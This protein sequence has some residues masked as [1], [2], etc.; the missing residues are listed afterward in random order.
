MIKMNLKIINASIIN[1]TTRLIFLRTY[2]IGSTEMYVNLIHVLGIFLI[3]LLSLLL[4]HGN[5]VPLFTWQCHIMYIESDWPGERL[6]NT[7]PHARTK[8]HWLL[9]GEFTLHSANTD[10]ITQN[11]WWSS[12]QKTTFRQSVNENKPDIDLESAATIGHHIYNQRERLGY[13]LLSE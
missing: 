5:H 11:L 10:A 2:D 1:A 12:K 7:Y 9:H 3:P 4:F 6:I 8:F 13:V